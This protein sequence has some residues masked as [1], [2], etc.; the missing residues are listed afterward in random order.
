MIEKTTYLTRLEKVI[1]SLKEK[2]ID[3]LL[4]N[5]THNIAYLTGTINSSSWVFITK[6]GK[7]VALVLDSD[8]DIYREESAIDEIRTF[9]VHDPVHLFER[10]I[11]DLR[12]TD[13]KIG[14]EYSIPGL[15]YLYVNMLKNAFPTSVQFVNGEIA[16]EE[17]RAIK[18]EEEIESIKKAAKIAELG[19][20]VAIKTIKPGL[21]EN[22]VLI[23]VEY[24]MKK[25]GGGIGVRNYLASG[26][27]SCLAH[28]I[29]SK[30]II[31]IGD[32]VTL[33]I[34]GAFMGY[35]ADLAR[36][37]ICGKANKEVEHAYSCLNRAE[38]ETISSFRSGQKLTE[39]KKVFYKKLSEAK[40][41]KFLMD[42]LLHGVGIMNH[43]M[44]YFQ[45]PYREKGY[46]ETLES[47]MV[48]AVSNIGLY[49]NQG[50]GVRVED[51]VL[52]T[53]NKPI[54]LTKFAKELLHI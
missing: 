53:D 16:V 50:W 1:N 44:P 46:P 2:D 5:R 19:M 35:C 26:K 7:K 13:S 30:K 33:D 6:E 24:M 43:E 22:E 15:P 27:R 12:L 38:E 31:E 18:S 8:V 49:S 52:V 48:V 37:V 10:V 23:E 40:N 28:H 9:R 17:I 21:S 11:K 14:L 25:A 41:M 34:H 29:P 4:L 3:A 36:T 42:P 20:E 45:Y 32:V 39:V 54:Y 51:T 47:N